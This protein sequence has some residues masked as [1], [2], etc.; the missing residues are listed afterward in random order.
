MKCEYCG[1]DKLP[2]GIKHPAYV[3]IK[4]DKKYY[5]CSKSCFVHWAMRE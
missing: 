5:F 3:V 1:L 2:K 4:G